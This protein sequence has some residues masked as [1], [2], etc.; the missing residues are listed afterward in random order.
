[1]P[2]LAVEIS[3]F[4][5]AHF[6]GFVECE[7]VDAGGARHLFIEKASIVSAGVLG[8]TSQYPRSGAI[9]CA[10]QKEWQDPEG[11]S[12]AQVTTEHP[13]GVESISGKS[14]FVVLSLLLQ[15]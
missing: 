2:S 4:V 15:P 3:R 11:R 12:L 7:L 14:N 1:M 5:D 8:S 9:P 10:V 6:P 13:C